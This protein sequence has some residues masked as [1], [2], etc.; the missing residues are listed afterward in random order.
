VIPSRMD[1]CDAPW[2]WFSGFCESN[3]RWRPEVRVVVLVAWG[4]AASIR[5]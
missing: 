1:R 3:D 4:W 2:I 5:V